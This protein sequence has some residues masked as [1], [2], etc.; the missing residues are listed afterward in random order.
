MAPTHS[1]VQK[2]RMILFL[3]KMSEKILII[4]TKHRATE[5]S[6]FKAKYEKQF[7]IQTETEGTKQSVQ[8]DNFR[9][10]AKKEHENK[11]QSKENVSSNLAFKQKEKLAK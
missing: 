7:Q 4:E 11:L 6:C 3:K 10:L 1:S 5:W 8:Q 2:E 9:I